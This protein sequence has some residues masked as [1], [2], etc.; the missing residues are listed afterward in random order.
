MRLRLYVMFVVLASLSDE[1]LSVYPTRPESAD[2]RTEKNFPPDP[3]F[4][5]PWPLSHF[6]QAEPDDLKEQS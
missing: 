1:A 4:L 3:M 6:A 5:F 2:G